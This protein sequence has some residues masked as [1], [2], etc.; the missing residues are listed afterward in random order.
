VRRIHSASALPKAIV[1]VFAMKA[2]HSE[3]V[4]V[5]VFAKETTVRML[6]ELVLRE[7]GRRCPMCSGSLHCFHS[8]LSRHFHPLEDLLRVVHLSMLAE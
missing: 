1:I 4:T 2:D 6:V 8:R 7:T 5:A 3:A